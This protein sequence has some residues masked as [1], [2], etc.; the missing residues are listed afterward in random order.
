MEGA[1]GACPFGKTFKKSLLS[2]AYCI[3][4]FIGHESYEARQ[5]IQLPNKQYYIGGALKLPSYY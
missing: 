2:L 5:R 1:K 4:N 3:N